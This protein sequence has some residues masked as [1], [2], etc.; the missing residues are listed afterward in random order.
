MN[1]DVEKRLLSV[2]GEI[3]ITFP[4]AIK[5]PDGKKK[6]VN[7]VDSINKIRPKNNLLYFPTPNNSA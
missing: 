4:V 1:D 5:Y 6:V 2:L 7:K 3:G